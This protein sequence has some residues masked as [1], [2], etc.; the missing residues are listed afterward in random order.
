MKRRFLCGGKWGCVCGEMC[1]RL[2]RDYRGYLIQISS[3]YNNPLYRSPA[4]TSKS[5]GKGSSLLHY[6][7]KLIVVKFNFIFN[8]SSYFIK[9]KFLMGLPWWPSGKESAFQCRGCG[10]DPWSGNLDL[11]CRRATKLTPHNYW[12]RAP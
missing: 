1:I 7:V 2:E 5:L 9:V 8:S 12:A 6:L 11:T 4:S 10:F 3:Q